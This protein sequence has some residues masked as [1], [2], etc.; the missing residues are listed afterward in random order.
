MSFPQKC[1]PHGSVFLVIARRLCCMDRFSIVI[2]RLDRGI[3]LKIL[4]LLVV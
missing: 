1:C 4:K 2:P 3:Q